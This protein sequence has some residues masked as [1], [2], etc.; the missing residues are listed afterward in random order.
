MPKSN[1]DQPTKIYTELCRLYEK[2]DQ[3]FYDVLDSLVGIFNKDQLNQVE[4]ILVNQF[5]E[6]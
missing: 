5:G 4:D 2:N 3:S 6:T 1:Y